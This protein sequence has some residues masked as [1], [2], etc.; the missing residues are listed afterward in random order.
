MRAASTAALRALSTPTQATGTPGGIWAI[1][2]SASSPPATDVD[3][4]SGTP[5]TGRSVCAATTPG[6]AADRPAPAMITRSPRSFALR[7]YSATVSG[8]RWADMT[9]T[10]CWISSC[11]S[12]RAAFCIFSMSDF[13]PM[14]MPTRGP[15]TGT[16]ASAGSTAVSTWGSVIGD[17]RRSHRGPPWR[18]LGA[19]LRA[20]S[21]GDVPPVGLA[22][23]RDHVGGSIRGG[24]GGRHVVAERRHVEHAPAGG[25]HRAVAL[26][27]AGVR[28]L[29][30]G[31]DAVEAADR[32]AARGGHGVAARGEHDRHRGAWIPLDP[33]AAQTAGL[34]RALEQLEQVGAQ[35]RQHGLGLRVPEADVE[36]EHPRA[37]GGEHETGV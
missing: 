9:R 34:D 4:V 7:A 33:G 15:A 16:S 23:E 31:R 30:L 35:P 37:A 12:S 32:V 28:D 22:V 24:P 21:C 14:T 10:S 27:G 5:I 3:E 19:S 6:S 36:L 29:G 8:S 1:D 17:R 18:S 2:S 13:E 25:D 20:S 11:S 26:G